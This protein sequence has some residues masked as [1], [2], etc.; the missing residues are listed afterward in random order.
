MIPR[1]NGRH[2]LKQSQKADLDS[3]GDPQNPWYQVFHD[4][5]CVAI[6]RGFIEGDIKW[7]HVPFEAY[8]VARNQGDGGLLAAAQAFLKEAE[9]EVSATAVA[10]DFLLKLIGKYTNKTPINT[11]PFLMHPILIPGVTGTLWLAACRFFQSLRRRVLWD[12]RIGGLEDRRPAGMQEYGRQ[13]LRDC[14]NVGR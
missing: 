14:R 8:R 4:D 12:C 5:T 9:G 10:Q 13:G 2:N 3:P 7:T 11:W 6:V 1:C